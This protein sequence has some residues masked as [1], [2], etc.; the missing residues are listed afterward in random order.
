MDAAMHAGAWPKT[1]G[2]QLDGR[3]VAVVGLGRIGRRVAQLATAFGARILAVDPIASASA[4]EDYEFRTLSDALRDATLVTLHCS[5]ETEVL[6]ATELAQLPRGAFVLNGARGGVV[7]ERALQAALDSGHVAGAWLD[8]F[9]QEPYTGS[10]RGYPQVLLT[11]H[12]GSYSKE[13]RLKMET[14]AARNLVDAFAS[15][16]VRA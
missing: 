2:G 14:E 6:G 1:R 16:P 4:P 11:P 3:T 9:A 13:C 7:N 8:C 5:G 10:L 15:A 12:V